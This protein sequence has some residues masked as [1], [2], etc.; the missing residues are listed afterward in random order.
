MT[1]IS[2]CQKTKMSMKTFM[3]LYNLFIDFVS[4]MNCQISHW[5][6]GHQYECCEIETEADQARD[7]HD[8]G[9][10]SMLVEKPE[11]VRFLL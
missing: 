4:S 8:H 9:S 11:M 7:V 3:N 10:T 2:I 6:S 1:L 5:R